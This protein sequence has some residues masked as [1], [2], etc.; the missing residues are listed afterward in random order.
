MK[1][2]IKKIIEP[3][4]VLG[5]LLF[6]LGMGLLIYVFGFHLEESWIAYIAYLLSAYALVIFVV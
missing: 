2:I 6:N 4:K 3:N 1:V 5:F